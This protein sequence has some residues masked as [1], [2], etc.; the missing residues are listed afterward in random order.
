MN[1]PSAEVS[2]EKQRCLQRSRGAGEEVKMRRGA[3]EQSCR[4]RRDPEVQRCKGG[5][6]WCR[7]GGA[8]VKR[9]RGADAEVLRCE[10]LKC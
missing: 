3:E 10:V 7:G 4:W 8:A 6:G 5:G 9:S 1:S 2:A